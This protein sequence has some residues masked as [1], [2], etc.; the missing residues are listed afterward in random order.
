MLAHGAA[1]YGRRNWRLSSILATTYVGAIRRH[2]N[3][4]AD[5]EDLDPDSGKSHLAHIRACCAVVMDA[6]DCGTMDDD[7]H[8]VEATFQ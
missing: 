3:A 1:K 7:R 6:Q 2:L 4:W 8:F 5:G